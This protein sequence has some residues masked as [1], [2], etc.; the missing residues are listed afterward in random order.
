[1]SLKDS[2]IY[3]LASFSRRRRFFRLDYFLRKIY[4]PDKRKNDFIQQV[5]LI[6]ENLLFNV[7]TSSYLEW[8]IFFYGIYEPFIVVLFKHFLQQGNVVIDIGANVGMHSLIMG[9]TV[10]E[11]G[12][13]YSFEPHPLIFERLKKNLSLN[14]MSWVKPLE[15]GLSDK[16]GQLYLHGFDDNSAN[17]GTSSLSTAR[18]DCEVNKNSVFKVDVVTLDEWVEKEKLERLD[19]IKIDTEGHDFNVLSGGFK[20]IESFRP[21][22]IFE[23]CSDFFAPKEG[24]DKLNEIKVRLE[25]M[26]YKL[27]QIKHDFLIDFDVSN[28]IGTLNFV[29]VP[30][31]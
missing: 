19:L 4:N 26:E 20:T 30:F 18:K 15:N 11:R 31:F 23:Y 2:F 6:D 8:Y 21:V 28:L 9:K 1:M 5:I 10:G 22:I 13:V 3:R 17:K 14:R 29:A 7:D 25:N 27:Y 16:S 24:N 12:R